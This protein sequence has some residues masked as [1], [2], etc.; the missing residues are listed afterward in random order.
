MGTSGSVDTWSTALWAVEPP[1]L[2]LW[3]SWMAPVVIRS[4]VL[5]D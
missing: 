3:F 4:I 5:Y 2:Y 1:Y